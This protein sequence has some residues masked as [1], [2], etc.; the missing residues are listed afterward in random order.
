MRSKINKKYF[1]GII[2]FKK[3]ETEIEI[4]KKKEVN[5]ISAMTLQRKLVYFLN[6]QKSISFKFFS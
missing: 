6:I 3:S 1:F 5:Y 2:L 4:R